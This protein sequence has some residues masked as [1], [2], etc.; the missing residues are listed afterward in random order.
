[1]SE[2]P[3]E[4]SVDRAWRELAEI[5]A[6]LERGEIDEDGWHRRNQA[7][8]VPAYLAAATPQGGSGHSGD[9]ARWRLARE[10]V[11]DAVERDGTFLDVG[12]ANGLL[13]ESVVAW[14]RER[15]LALEPYGLDL[16][17]ELVALARQQLPHWHDRLYVGNAR[18]WT[19]PQRFDVVRTGL[20]YAPPTRRR[21]LVE[22]LLAHVVAPG[23]RLVIGVFNEPLAASPRREEVVAGWGYAIAG[24][25]S[26]PHRDP[27]VEYRAFWLDAPG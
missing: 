17:P 15:G 18:G 13:L 25:A 3:V 21:E 27:R 16:S 11:L 22:H 12:C 10:L 4:A 6:A 20:E 5:D 1:V 9:A 24:R 8:L 2:A 26:R 14:G 23:G 7:V 19:P